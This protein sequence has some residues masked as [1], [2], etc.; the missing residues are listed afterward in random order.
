MLS[1]LRVSF[2]SGQW[3]YSVTVCYST[4]FHSPA[5]TDIMSII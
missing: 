3:K 4:A 5:F 2:M 1:N